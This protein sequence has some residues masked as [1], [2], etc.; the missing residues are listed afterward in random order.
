[1]ALTRLFGSAMVAVSLFAAEVPAEEAVRDAELFSSATEV[2]PLL[3]GTAI[4]EGTLR[5]EKGNE[6]TVETL[7]GGGPAVF[8][9]YRGYW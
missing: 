8:V 9:F 3:V 4:P 2:R 6:T 5:D 1:M 7:M